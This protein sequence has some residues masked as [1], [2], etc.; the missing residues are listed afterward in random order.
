MKSKI[1]LAIGGILL[2]ALLAGGAFMGMRLINAG[3]QARNNNIGAGP[4]GNGLQLNMKGNG[5]GK[6]T[7]SVQMTPSPKLPASRPDF[8]GQVTGINNNSIVAVQQSKGIVV[9]SGAKAGSDS[10]TGPST[11]SETGPTPDSSSSGI[12]MEIV[13]AKETVIWR[14]TTMETNPRP[15][16]GSSGGTIGMEQTVEAAD[17]SQIQNGYLIQVWGQKRGDRLVAD[18]I[19]VQGNAVMIQKKP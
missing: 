9:Q 16:P 15:Q 14:D 8:V 7:F 11:S 17:L 12:T 19:C 13:V 10:G 4:S 2:V 3:A 6:V 18:V 5:G 1:L